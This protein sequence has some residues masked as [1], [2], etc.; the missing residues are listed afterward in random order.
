MP[1]SEGT[2]KEVI[3]R[4]PSVKSF[5]V[6][7]GATAD[8]QAGQF[9][10][11]TVKTDKEIKK[12]LSISSSPTEKG[13][14]EFTK[15]ITDSEFSRTLNHLKPGDSV[16]IQYPFGKFILDEKAPRIAFLSGGIGIA[17]IRS[18]FKYAV[19]KNIKNDM[20][21]FYGN[22]NIHEIAFKDELDQMQNQCGNLRVLHVLMEPCDKF[23]CKVGFITGQIIKDSIPDFIERKFYV[24]GPPAM[25]TA[26]RRILSEELLVPG[27]N[28]VSEQF[29]GY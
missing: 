20:V 6:D 25:V 21:L 13:Y 1:E 14:I 7:V 22:K 28:I 26:M 3:Q 4:T 2:I 5:R 17:P 12:Y 29:Q 11:V 10:S 23:S 24:C 15:K 16:K 9:L 19:D 27:I 8:F 18:I